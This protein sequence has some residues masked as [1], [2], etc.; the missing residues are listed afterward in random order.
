MVGGLRLGD[1]FQYKRL[2]FGLGIEVEIE[3]SKNEISTFKY[4]G[5]ESPAGTYVFSGKFRPNPFAV[6]GPRVGYA[7]NEWLPY[8]TAGAVIAAG[9]QNGTATFTPAGATK[10]TAS[11]SGARGF[12]STGWAAGAGVE[13]GL[14]GP[15]SIT[16]QYL[17]AS[18]GNGS[19]AT[20]SC[21]GSIAACS[22]FAGN[23]L[24]NA[25]TGNTTH[26]F[27]IGINYWFGYW[28]P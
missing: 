20:A 10:P 3:Q 6:V 23:P 27:L 1:N 21:S 2:L 17:Y 18:L 25:R 7:G 11:F 16:A 14:N 4:A 13:W 15:W 5:N 8:V 12:S 19:R 26:A 22:A 9:T 24:E 28:N